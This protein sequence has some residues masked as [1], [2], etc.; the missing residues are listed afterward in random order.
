LHKS[1]QITHIGK[2]HDPHFSKTI[3]VFGIG[4]M[5]SRGRKVVV[6]NSYENL[7]FLKT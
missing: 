3:H 6:A 5:F 2:D 7:F 4:S 1:N